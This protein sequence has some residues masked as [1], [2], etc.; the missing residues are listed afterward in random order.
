MSRG[1]GRLERA[2]EQIFD[3]YPWEKCTV[4]RLWWIATFR[5]EPTPAETSLILRAAQSVL[6]HRRLDWCATGEGLRALFHHRDVP[7]DELESGA[8]G[9]LAGYFRQAEAIVR[10][11]RN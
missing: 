2:V 8:D 6:L 11:P 3:E 1:P 9:P 10:R 5:R 7:H 4:S